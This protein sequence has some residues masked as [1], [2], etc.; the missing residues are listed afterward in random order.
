MKDSNIS[1]PV[2]VYFMTVT[3]WIMLRR[4]AGCFVDNATRKGVG[5]S[6]NGLMEV[7]S[8]VLRC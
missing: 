2:T 1:L 4:K 8:L 3:I 6:S 7:L 5:G